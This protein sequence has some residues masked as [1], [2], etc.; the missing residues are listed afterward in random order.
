M[1]Y[2]PEVTLGSWIGYDNFYSARYSITESDG[3]GHPTMRSLRNWTSLMNAVYSA[4]PSLFNQST[5]FVQ[6]STV[7]QD[8]VVSVTG[9][10]PGTATY[11][12]QTYSIGGSTTTDLFKKDYGPIAP[13]YHFAVGATNNELDRYWNGLSDQEKEAEKKKAEKEKEASEDK[14]KK[15]SSSSEKPKSSSTQTTKSRN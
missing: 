9:T 3:Y 12:G 2:T 8:S 4:K 7:Y 1:G 11:N 14:D 15:K 5:K 13:T 10:K 6:P